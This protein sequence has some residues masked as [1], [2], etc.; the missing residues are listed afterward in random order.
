[1]ARRSASE[2]AAAAPGR[3]HW[4]GLRIV[5]RGLAATAAAILFLLVLMQIEEFIVSDA[6]FKL[7]GPPPKALTDPHFR[8]AGV[9]YSNENQIVDVF[10]RD[11]GRSIYLVPLRERRE[12]LLRID[13]IEDAAISRVWP[14]RLDV[15]IRERRPVAFVQIAGRGGVMMPML[16]DKEGV[17]L[18]TERRVR[19]RLPV[20]T[21]L[22]IGD[23][24]EA[25]RRRVQRL[26]EVQRDLG[27]LMDLVS[28]VDIN[29]IGVVRVTRP[30]DGRAVVLILGREEYAKRMR[31]LLDNWS[32]VRSRLPNATII[33]LRMPDRFIAVPDPSATPVP[34]PQEGT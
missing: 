25:R 3:E 15:S 2:V 21:G 28:E 9:T 7:P 26:V 14:D 1:M 8:L 17:L 30:F 12:Q 4:T 29:E 18:E 11:F 24:A 16:I 19:L 32:E 20:L 34:T 31:R 33:D 5:G 6:R 27:S 13:W 22:R 10:A 23:S